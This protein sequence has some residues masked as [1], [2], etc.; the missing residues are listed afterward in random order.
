MIQPTSVQR[1]RRSVQSVVTSSIFLVAL[2]RQWP[3]KAGATVESRSLGRRSGLGW[4]WW[5][6]V[7][8]GPGCRDARS[9][10]CSAFART[11]NPVVMELEQIRRL[12]GGNQREQ[13]ARLQAY[14]RWWKTLAARLRQLSVSS[15]ELEPLVDQYRS[16]VER[17]AA[18]AHEQAQALEA[19]DQAKLEAAA[20]RFQALVTEQQAVVSEMHA[21]C[22]VLPL[23]SAS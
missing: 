3:Q 4:C 18:T 13:L 5:L 17:A 7:L 12:P 20:R 14:E 22:G 10:E 16:V 21:R 15:S 19:G 9:T 1:H 8:L 23:P 6:L 11:V 2:G